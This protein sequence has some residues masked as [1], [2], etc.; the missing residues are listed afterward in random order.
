MLVAMSVDEE[1]PARLPEVDE[2]DGVELAPEILS[3]SPQLFILLLKLLILRWVR[4]RPSNPNILEPGCTRLR[5]LVLP[6]EELELAINP[7]GGFVVVLEVG[8]ALEGE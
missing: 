6:D 3:S 8:D 1:A 2:E 4:D 7:G 5:V